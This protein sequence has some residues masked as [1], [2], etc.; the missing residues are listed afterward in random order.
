[1][2]DETEQYSEALKKLWEAFDDFG[3]VLGER[4]CSI[5][6]LQEGL[7]NYYD[8]LRKDMS[9]HFDD[10]EKALGERGRSILELQEGLSNYYDSLRKDMSTHFDD[11]EK[12]LGERGHVVA[13]VLN[14]SN[15]AAETRYYLSP[16]PQSQSQRDEAL[17]ATHKDLF[18]PRCFWD[19]KYGRFK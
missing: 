14:D 18:I 15:S 6:E 13:V 2:S 10:L 8:S 3:K 4:G 11:L 1:M 5:L 19:P 7:S 9:T 12:A 16:P 17:M